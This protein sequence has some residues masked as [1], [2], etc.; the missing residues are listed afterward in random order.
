M[1]NPRKEPALP[2]Y[3]HNSGFDEVPSHRMPTS[4]QP[5]AATQMSKSKPSHATHGIFMPDALSAATSLF[6]GLRT[7]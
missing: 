5:A 3:W 7:G 6:S 1:K 4:S 2:L